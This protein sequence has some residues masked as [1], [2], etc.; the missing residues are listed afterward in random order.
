M[1]NWSEP[2]WI[3]E[4]L[5]RK[6]ESGRILRCLIFEDTVFPLRIPIFNRIVKI[7]TL[8]LG[9]AKVD[10]GNTL[11]KERIYEEFKL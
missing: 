7:G 4:E 10:I 11:Q 3:R 9:K 1:S 2:K 8:G 6:W 5:S